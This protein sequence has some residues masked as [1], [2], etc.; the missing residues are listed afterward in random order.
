MRFVFV[1]CLLLLSPIASLCQ[2]PPPSAADSNPPKE[3]VTVSGTVLRLDT[4]EPLKK[5]D[6][7]LQ[8][9]SGSRKAVYDVTDALGHFTLGSVPPG[10]YILIV[11]RNG[12]VDAEFG[13]QR[14]GGPGAVLTLSA[15]QRLT[16]LVF[17][18]IHTC[19]IS[20]HVYDE[21][22]FPVRGA[23]ISIFRASAREG[24]ALP[25]GGAPISTNDLGEFRIFDLHPGRY[26]VSVFY[27][28]EVGDHFFP[29]SPVRDTKE[30]YLPAYFPNTTDAARALP[31]VVHAGDEI[32][33]IDFFLQPAL[34]V[35]VTGKVISAVP[36][37]SGVDAN[38]EIYPRD[39]GL[40]QSTIHL[41]AIPDRKDGTFQIRNVPPGTYSVF[42]SIHDSESRGWLW[43]K[44]EIEVG[45]IDVD[46]VV[47]IITQGIDLFGRVS[48]EGSAPRGISDLY[49][50]L[51]PVD[52][53]DRPLPSQPVRANGSFTFKNVPEGTYRPFVS[54]PEQGAAGF[55]KSAKYGSLSVPDAG[56]TLRG[57]PE[58]LLELV[59][60]SHCAQVSGLVLTGDSLPAVGV[61]VVLVPDPPRRNQHRVFKVV[62]TDQNGRFIISGIEPSDYKLFSWESVEDQDWF[63]QDWLRPYESKGESVHLEEGDLKSVGL[64]LIETP[65]AN[66][67]LP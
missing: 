48:W 6:V 24:K 61:Q 54:S 59:M 44:R 21:D 4:G 11:S 53:P 52:E 20:G 32:R 34:M 18:L 5:A 66:A 47:L 60:S 23:D 3:L 55:L 36:N 26:Y 35:K 17:K 62:T 31:I 38:V 25:V 40:A 9:R 10:S 49:V 56:F 12:Y 28:P 42:S 46:G 65:K 30:G 15:G 41:D 19:A 16:D 7:K 50:W 22:G 45:N 63:D 43:T 27:H 57:R 2:T 13:Q 29:F 37:T 39:S 1:S 67:G 51:E 64:T 58:G 14:P 33:D 8:S